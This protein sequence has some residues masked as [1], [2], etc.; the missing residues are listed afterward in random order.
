MVTHRGLQSP[1]MYKLYTRL[2]NRVEK[3]IHLL[4]PIMK[5]QNIEYKTTPNA[6]IRL[7]NDELKKGAEIEGTI[8]IHT[9]ANNEY[10]RFKASSIDGIEGL[11]FELQF[12]IKGYDI[13]SG[14][15]YDR[16]TGIVRYTYLDGKVAIWETEDEL[17]LQ[18]KEEERLK[19]IQE[20]VI[21]QKVS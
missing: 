18:L 3:D 16:P 11:E 6:S 20:K 1:R 19:K 9:P 5:R 7:V 17:D 2:G 12:G 21:K 14:E 8:P 4:E 10:A 13:H 15:A